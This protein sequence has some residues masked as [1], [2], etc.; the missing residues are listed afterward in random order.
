MAATD[1]DASYDR[2]PLS[3]RRT[4]SASGNQPVGKRAAIWTFVVTGLTDAD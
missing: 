2:D 3:E 1:A 4:T